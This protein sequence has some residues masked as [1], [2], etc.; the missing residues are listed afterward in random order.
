M[1]WKDAAYSDHRCIHDERKRVAT[2]YNDEVGVEVCRI[3]RLRDYKD[4]VRVGV[5]VECILCGPNKH[6]TAQFD[7]NGTGVYSV[8]AKTGA[9]K[10]AWENLDTRMPT[11]DLFVRGHCQNK[12]HTENLKKAGW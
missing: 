3:V 6:Y 4:D 7:E 5:G 12:T 8:G 1:L 9:E 10:S 11:I 2:K